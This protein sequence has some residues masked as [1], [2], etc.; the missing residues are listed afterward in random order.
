MKMKISHTRFLLIGN[1]EVTDLEFPACLEKKTNSARIDA[2]TITNYASDSVF[3]F[4]EVLPSLAVSFQISPCP[5]RLGEFLV[6]MDVV[7][8]TNSKS[9]QVHQLS[10]VGNAWEI[11][12]L[13]PI[14]AIFPS[15][16]L[17]AG[18]ALSCFFKLK[19]LLDGINLLFIDESVSGIVFS[20]VSSCSWNSRKSVPI[21]DEYS[22]TSPHEGSDV[23]LSHGSNDLLF[24]I[25]RSPLVDF[26]HYERVHRGTANQLKMTIHNS[27]KDAASIRID[28]SDSTSIGNTTSVSSGNEAGWYDLSLLNDVTV[29]SDV[30]GTQVGKS[31]SRE[32]ISPF[33]WSGTS[34]TRIKL[35]PM[36][37]TEIPL[38]ICVFSPGT[39]DLSNY[40]LHW[41][42][43]PSNDQVNQWNG[44][45]QSLGT[46]QGHPYCLTVLQSS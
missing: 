8:R 25:S 31:L 33:I 5:L 23:S 22:S 16:L 44:T 42:F 14:D 36:S 18:Q 40:S 4:P 26:H 35:E 2:Q 21:D 20:E 7:N 17:L 43:C 34:S 12:L 32:C 27:S 46:C 45:R 10:S 38:P 28:T 39:Y 1:Q 15:D 37:T 9:F 11:S 24:D 6:R 3:Q 29:T 19:L 30:L 41:K 13:Q